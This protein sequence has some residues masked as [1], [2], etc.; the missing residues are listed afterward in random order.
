M[1]LCSCNVSCPPETPPD[2]YFAENISLGD[3]AFEPGG[4]YTIMV[5]AN[6]TG[7]VNITFVAGVTSYLACVDDMEI[8]S[9][10]SSPREYF[11]DVVS[12][13]SSFC[14]H[15]CSYNVTDAGNATIIVE[16]FNLSCGTDCTPRYRN[17]EH[18]VPLGS[19]FVSGGNYTVVV[20]NV[21]ENFV[22][23]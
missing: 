3:L 5:N 22:A 7:N 2:S 6:S 12:E 13:E 4:N 16:I 9:D 23:E 17:V 20:N 1:L 10:N 14:D 19:D 21:T 11:V 18:T 8:W 15:F